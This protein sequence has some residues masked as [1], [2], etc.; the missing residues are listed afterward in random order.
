MEMGANAELN[1]TF[2]TTARA[3]VPGE[4]FSNSWYCIWDHGAEMKK[5]VVNIVREREVL[6]VYCGVVVEDCEVGGGLL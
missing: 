4:I 2:W 5:P 6:N 3:W 1:A